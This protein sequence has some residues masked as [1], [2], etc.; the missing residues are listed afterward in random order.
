MAIHGFSVTTVSGEY[1][2]NSEYTL[3][4]KIFELQLS[5]V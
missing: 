5:F 2:R 3:T 1:G 4:I